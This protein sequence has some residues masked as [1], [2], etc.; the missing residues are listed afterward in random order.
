MGL[1]FIQEHVRKSIPFVIA[2][3]VPP[4]RRRGAH[5][6]RALTPP[7]RA[8]PLRRAQGRIRDT[9]KTAQMCKCAHPSAAVA[10]ASKAPQSLML[11]V[12]L[13][14]GSTW[15]PGWTP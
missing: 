4:A 12:A 1:Y 3:K 11:H 8:S 14:A 10:G 2:T 7:L 13:R 5:A 6:R 15:T 9:A